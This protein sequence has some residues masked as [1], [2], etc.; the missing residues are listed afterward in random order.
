M[1]PVRRKSPEKTGERAGKSAAAARK[2]STAPRS[3]AQSVMVVEDHPMMREAIVLLLQQ[4]PSFEVVLATGDPAAALDGVCSLN[5]DIVLLDMTLP[6]K[7]GLELLKDM[8]AV[9]RDL[10]VLV[11]SMH[12]E[13]LYAERVLKAG[14]RGYIMKSAGS[15]QLAEAVRTVAS[16]RVYISPEISGRI[17]EA[18]SAG[19]DATKASPIDRLTDREFAV[20][21]LV[22]QGRTTKEIGDRLHISPKTVE[23]HRIAI[24]KKLGLGTAAELAHHATLWVNSQPAGTIE[25]P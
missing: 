13:S 8:R 15:T 22:G 10:K 18:F 25:T 20:F 12:D 11:L 3:A 17:V 1:K 14:G 16:G 6:G 19:K 5:P 23:V 9:K 7:N 2:P 4:D 21:Q 24:K